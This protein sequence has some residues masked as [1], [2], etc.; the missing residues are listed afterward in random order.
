[1]TKHAPFILLDNSRDADGLTYLFENPER[2]I[3]A[4][5]PDG[6]DAALTE[7][8]AALASGLHAAGFFSYELGYVLEPHLA[9][10]LPPVRDMPLLWFALFR[11]RK[12]L[13][14]GC[15]AAWIKSRMTGDYAI[16]VPVPE[17]DEASYAARFEKLRRYIIEGDVYQINLTFKAHVKAHGDL[18]ALYHDLRA[19]Q[20]VAYGA[21]VQGEDFT[22]LS[23]SPELFVVKTGVQ[24]ETR[25]MK[26]TA[27]LE[28]DP[29]A[30]P[31]DA[32]AQAENRM[33][34]DLM[35]NDFGRVAELG[36]VKVPQMFAVETYRTLHQMISVVTAKV[37]PRL[38]LREYVKALFPP[39]SVTGAPKIRAQEIIHE[40]E[41]GPRGIYTGAIGMLSPDGD[42]VFNV[43]IRTLKVNAD[44]R[45]EIGLGSG[46]VY[47]SGAASEYAECLLKMRFLQE[48]A[49]PFRLIETLRYEDGEFIRL[50]LHLARLSASATVFGFACDP[51]KIMAALQNHV[52]GRGGIL[53]IRLTLGEDGAVEVSSTVLT[54][55]TQL[56]FAV[57]GKRVSSKDLFLAHKTSR[58]SF[59]DKEREAYAAEGADEVLFLNERGE[60]TQGSFTNLFLRKG[61]GPLLTPPKESGLLPGV[62]RTSLLQTGEAVEQVL[63]VAELDSAEEIYF[64]NSLRGLMR[65]ARS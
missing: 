39:G 14:P 53:R 51:A 31:R 48:W 20:P 29:Q 56:R 41:T 15:G 1:M 49:Q 37:K 40:L 52:E 32:K 8:E 26:G 9:P 50:P 33:I 44:G 27:P 7:L 16:S 34:V 65:A 35:R 6:I 64:G 38:S 2:I 22:L 45:G 30:L 24:L 63:T 25:P 43:A 59:W 61:N 12:T 11:E 28:T 19:S 18:L 13:Q 23:R 58:R 36:S 17:W 62:L 46:V 5:A 60:V 47:D 57:S 55:L 54:P 4:D 21:F 3:R 10:L 42:H